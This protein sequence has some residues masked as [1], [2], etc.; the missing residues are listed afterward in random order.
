MTPV[1]LAHDL[2]IDVKRLRQW[3]RDGAYPR[4]PVDKGKRYGD[5]PPHVVAAARANQWVTR[6]Q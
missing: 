1:E 6:H 5:L 4:S 2:G 3:L